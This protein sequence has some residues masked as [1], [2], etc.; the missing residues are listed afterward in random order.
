[1]NSSLCLAEALV[2]GFDAFVTTLADQYPPLAALRDK[3]LQQNFGELLP[4][5]L[6]GA[7]VQWLEAS[8]LDE[9]ELDVSI[10]W[11]TPA[12]DG[13]PPAPYGDKTFDDYGVAG[14]DYWYPREIPG[15][16]CPTGASLDHVRT[17]YAQARAKVSGQALI[18]AWYSCS[19]AYSDGRNGVWNLVTHT[20]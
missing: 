17:A 18:R 13:D 5:V 9:S 8:V 15:F 14:M 1:M 2:S 19:P 11:P 16:G 12:F 7:F 20:Q 4:Y 3:H 10:E 6:F